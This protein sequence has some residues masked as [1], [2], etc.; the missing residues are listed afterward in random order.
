[1]NIPLPPGYSGAVPFDKNIHRRLGVSDTA[2][3]FA[4][5]LHFIYLST[6]EI[7][8][9]ALDY[10]V[11][12]ARDSSN[13]IVP[14]ALLGVESGSNLFVDEQGRWRSE[15]YCPAYVR[16]YPFFMAQIAG[17]ERRLICVDDTALDECDAELIN[18]LGELTSLGEEKLKLVEQMAAAEQRTREMCQRLQGAGLFE[19]F[20]ADFH[21]KGKPAKRINGLLRVQASTLAKV[22]PERLSELNHQQDLQV[23]FSHI[24]SLQRFERVLNLYAAS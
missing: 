14:G 24:S 3:T 20:D 4:S 21:P 23:V 11:V 16:R 1:M 2:A 12:F 8:R 10:P 17:D 6:E 5:Q 15:Y 7:P 9:A 13:T 22:D 18:A 19:T